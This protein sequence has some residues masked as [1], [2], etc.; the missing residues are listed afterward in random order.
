MAVGHRCRTRI[1]ILQELTCLCDL[2]LMAHHQSPCRTRCA[3]DLTGRCFGKMS[4][5]VSIVS[6]S[7][8]SIGQL[9]QTNGNNPAIRDERDLREMVAEYLVRHG[10][11]VRTA[12][13]GEAMAARRQEKSADLVILDIN[14]PGEDG[15][16]LARRL[17]EHSDVCIMMLTAAGEM[18]MLRSKVLS[19][20]GGS[21]EIDETPGGGATFKIRLPVVPVEARFP[22]SP[23]P[24]S[25][26]RRRARSCRD[27]GARGVCSRGCL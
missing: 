11:N 21:I 17:R 24:R 18:S 7:W 8:I 15:L 6:R 13:D 25:R 22:R 16:T 9:P 1:E 27:V 26:R 19:I 5:I 4:R 20:P 10:S 23:A 12:L 2:I 14:I 3:T